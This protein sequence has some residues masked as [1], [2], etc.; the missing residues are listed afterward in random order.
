MLLNEE[1]RGYIGTLCGKLKMIA[2]VEGPHEVDPAKRTKESDQPTNMQRYIKID[3]AQTALNLSHIVFAF[4]LR[5]HKLD[6]LSSFLPPF[7][8]TAQD[9]YHR[10]CLAG[11]V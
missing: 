7:L 3:S 11:C 1:N 2:A 6:I 10:L 4:A 5:L 8:W 9:T